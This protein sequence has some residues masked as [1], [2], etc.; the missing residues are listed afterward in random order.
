MERD[1]AAL[2][3]KLL[4]Q[5]RAQLID[6]RFVIAGRFHLYSVLQSLEHLGLMQEGELEDL[7]EKV[8]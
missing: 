2:T 4:R 6:R 1:T 7:G 3:L 5:M 8:G